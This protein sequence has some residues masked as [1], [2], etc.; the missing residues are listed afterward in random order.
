MVSGKISNSPKKE[1]YW[2]IFVQTQTSLVKSLW[3][4]WHQELWCSASWE[5]LRRMNGKRILLAEG[6]KGCWVAKTIEYS[7]RSDSC[8]LSAVHIPISW[9]FK[10]ILFFKN[11]IILCITQN[12]YTLSQRKTDWSHSYF[13]SISMAWSRGVLL[14]VL[15]YSFTCNFL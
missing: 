11:V 14:Q 4:R 1:S 3:L 5:S 7:L 10:S 2:P 8:L 12:K 6:E 13:T 9:N 15:N